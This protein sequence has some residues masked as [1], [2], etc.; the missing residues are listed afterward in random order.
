MTWP[1]L[2]AVPSIRRRLPETERFRRVAG[3]ERAALAVGVGDALVH[4][5]ERAVRDL[6]AAGLRPCALQAALYAGVPFTGRAGNVVLFVTFYVLIM[7]MYGGGFAT[8]PAYLRD[9]FGTMHVGA[10]HGRLLTAWS[11]AGVAGPVLVNYLREYQLAHGVTKAE[12]YSI[13]M[14]LMAGL[15]VVG[16]AANWMVSAVDPKYRF[17]LGDAA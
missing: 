4:R 10:I 9:L 14:Y 17:Q 16:F 8:I 12:A 15:L 6:V 3:D 11:V 1:P 13:T 5:V 2:L 7:T